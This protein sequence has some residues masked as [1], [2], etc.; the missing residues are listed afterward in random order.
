[1]SDIASGFNEP[2]KQVIMKKETKQEQAAYE[3]ACDCLYYG[4]GRK[5]WNSCGLSEDDADRIWKD[6]I[7]ELTNCD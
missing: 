6:A 5:H 7:A 1:M 4:Y 3:N 2:N